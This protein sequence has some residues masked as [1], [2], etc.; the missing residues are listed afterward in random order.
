M[1]TKIHALVDAEGRAVRLSL[2]RGQAHD[3]PVGEALLK[4]IQPSGVL[5]GD[6][7]YDSRSLRSQVESRGGRTNIPSKRNARDK[8]PFSKSLYRQR[9]LVERF[10]NKLKQFRGLATRYDKR[11]ENFLAAV[12]L[13]SIRLWLRH[14]ESTA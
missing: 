11:P 7:A 1:T 12:K 3:C 8:P 4:T 5:L 13:V 14:N 2:S 10:F 6:K 9:N